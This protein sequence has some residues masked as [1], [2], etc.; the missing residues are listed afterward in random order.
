MSNTESG[1]Q[2]QGI[3]PLIGLD[4]ERLEAEMLRYHQWLDEHAD[5]AYIVAEKARNLGYDHKEFVEIP[6]AADLAGRTEKL[7]VEYLDGYEVAEDIRK[8]LAE[9][10]RETTSI[11]MAQSVARGFRERGYDLISGG[12]DNH[13]MLIDLSNKGVTGKLAE[14][15]LGQAH[16]T[17][18]K[19]MV[20]FDTQSPF[21]TSGIRVGTPAITTRGLLE[22]DMETIVAFIDEV[23]FNYEDE[24]VMESVAKR[25]NVM[26][27]HRPLFA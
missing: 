4:I 11:M 5:E 12:T 1:G 23:I 15:A 3:D 7:L 21:V 20:P 13:L 10:D 17:V 19:N 16:I 22:Y 27:G 24:A 18:N 9:H 2:K 26:M 8:L 25:V 14:Q 6:R